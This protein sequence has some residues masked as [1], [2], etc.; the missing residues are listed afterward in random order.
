[1][2][3]SL[4]LRTAKACY[5]ADTAPKKTDWSHLTKDEQRRYEVI[6]AAALSLALSEPIYPDLS[7]ADLVP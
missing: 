2:Q 6:A 5:R 7:M 1:M 4:L 3:E